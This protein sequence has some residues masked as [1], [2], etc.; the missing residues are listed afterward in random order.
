MIGRATIGYPWIFK[1]I[2][3]FMATGEHLDPPTLS[4]R[5]NAAQRHLELSVDW[6]GE[7]LAIA[8][9]RRHYGNYFRNFPNFKELRQTLVT[10][11]SLEMLRATFDEIRGDYALRNSFV[12]EPA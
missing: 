9:M 12:S 11:D 1:E 6:K 3:H 8:E 10:S 2:K 7:K 4:E 5:A